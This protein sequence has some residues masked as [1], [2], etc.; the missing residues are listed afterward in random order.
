MDDLDKDAAWER[1][2]SQE[3]QDRIRFMRNG[4]EAK[5]SVEFDG[6][7]L[8][9]RPLAI[10]EELEIEDLVMKEFNSAPEYKRTKRLMDY[11][12]MTKVLSR[13]LSPCPEQPEPLREK[14]LQLMPTMYLATLYAKYVEICKQLNPNIDTITNDQL[15]GL[16]G[17]LLDNPKL[18]NDCTQSELKHVCIELLRI[19]TILRG[20]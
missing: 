4:I 8:M 3:T 14:E 18:V 17:E 1:S 9:M 12:T 16:I 5:F 10:L 20:N 6:N 7:T 2:K 19:N 11:L 15:E 13:A